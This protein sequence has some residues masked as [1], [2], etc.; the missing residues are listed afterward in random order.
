[1]VLLR[2]NRTDKCALAPALW[3]SMA[4]LVDKIAREFIR[5]QFK[6]NFVLFQNSSIQDLTQIIT[7]FTPGEENQNQKYVPRTKMVLRDT[8]IGTRHH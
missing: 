8:P 5:A 7:G 3:L 4:D 1:L 2:N 6:I